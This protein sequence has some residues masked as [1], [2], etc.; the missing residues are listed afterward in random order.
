MIKTVTSHRDG[1]RDWAGPYTCVT[2][3]VNFEKY[4]I[5]GRNIFHLYPNMYDTL[6]YTYLLAYMLLYNW[7]NT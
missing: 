2:K 3:K 6:H 4:N 5:I 7:L 1:L